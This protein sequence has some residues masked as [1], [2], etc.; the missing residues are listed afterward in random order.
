MKFIY[1]I[2]IVLYLVVGAVPI[3]GALDKVVTQWVYLNTINT[4]SLIVFLINDK[5]L[6]KEYIFNK[7]SILFFCLFLW[8]AISS[9]FAINKMESLVVLSQLFAMVISFFIS[10]ICLSN[11]K[12]GFNFISNVI[13]IFLIFELALIF[14]PFIK[15]NIDLDLIFQRSSLF[16]GFAAN[17]NITAFSLLYKIPFLIYSLVQLRQIRGVFLVIISLTIFSL[18]FFASGTLNSTR[19]A[20]L[21]YTLISPLL[22]IVSTIIYFKYQKSKF[23]LISITYFLS[24][25]LSYPLNSFISESLN[26]SESNISSRIS[27]L[28]ALV[29]EEQ[30]KDG[31]L[32]QRIN[33]YSQAFNYI[34]KNPIIGTGI[35]NWKIKSIET[36]KDNI[37]GY[38]VPYHVHNDFLEIAS[39]IGLI[40]LGLYLLI[41]FFGFKDVI[42]ETW[43]MIFSKAKINKDNFISTV[44]SIYIL[45]FIID[46]NLNFPFA[47]PIVIINLIVLL[48]YLN[49]LKLIK[50]DAT[51]Q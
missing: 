49:S 4:V 3:L 27:T 28:T 10:L 46:S 5:S 2:I 38:Q 39:E 1:K 26:K 47:R 41:L 12:N 44:L 45:I 8:S 15:G 30:Q 13:S 19:G 31:S 18:I 22:L 42:I 7:S 36:N 6:K 51:R 16:L 11:I 37:I 43:Q 33:F 40:G 25:I 9:F 34:I 35:G 24:L 17:V 14:S 29:D 20:I 48:A 32:N 21:T 23:S 50:I